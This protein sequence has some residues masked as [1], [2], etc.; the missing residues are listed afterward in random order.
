[1]TTKT[2]SRR[3]QTK[4]E[5]R[6]LILEAAYDL[7]EEKGFAK[8][9][10]RE[11]AARA[12]V[13]LGT[14]FKHFPDKSALLLAAF[15]E[16][17]TQRWEKAF[18]TMPSTGLREQSKHSI[19]P[20][21]E[22][23]AARPELSRELLKEG[24]FVQGEAAAELLAQEMALSQKVVEEI[25]Q[26]AVDRGELNPEL[27]LFMFSASLWAHYICVLM[28]SLRTGCMDAKMMMAQLMVF[29][30]Q[31]MAGAAGPNYHPVPD[32][33]PGLELARTIYK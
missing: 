30:D 26:P 5:T 9:T 10:M 21:F 33:D 8:A 4:A 7:F 23:Y 14:I 32:S 1:M 16:D 18:A 3:E 28:I 29:F 15:K 2:G 25:Y 22:F 17:L 20:L 31:L 19:A 27:D 24:L 13:G 12:G 11:L 6:R